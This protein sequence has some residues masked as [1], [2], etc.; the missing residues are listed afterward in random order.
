MSKPTG[1][2]LRYIEQTNQARK[3]GKDDGELRAVAVSRTEPA[4]QHLIRIFTLGALYDERIRRREWRRQQVLSMR[5]KL[6]PEVADIEL[7]PESDVEP[8]LPL[9]QGPVPRWIVGTAKQVAEG[10]ANETREEMFARMRIPDLGWVMANQI[11]LVGK[12]R[13]VDGWSELTH[14]H[15]AGSDDPRATNHPERDAVKPGISYEFGEK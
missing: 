8:S 7:D 13:R 15:L 4:K 12:A 11:G 14:L 2:Y 10:K 3:A 1:D 6:N 5:R 9:L